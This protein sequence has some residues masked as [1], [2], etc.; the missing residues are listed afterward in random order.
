MLMLIVA[1]LEKLLYDPRWK[2]EQLDVCIQTFWECQ[3]KFTFL[4]LQWIVS[5]F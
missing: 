3:I 1:L 5:A 4:S 2:T